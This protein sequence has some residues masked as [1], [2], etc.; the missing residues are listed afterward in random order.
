MMSALTPERQQPLV[1]SRMATTIRAFQRAFG[2]AAEA[3]EVIELAGVTASVCPWLG[4]RSLFNA[5]AYDNAEALAAALPSL[6]DRYRR[7]GVTAWGVWAHESDAAANAIL[8]AAG[9]A[10]DSRPLAMALELAELAP[11]SQPSRIRVERTDDVEAFDAALA[12]A[13]DF[14]PTALTQSLPGLLDHFDGY[15]SRDEDGTPTAALAAVTAD[16]DCGITLVGTAPRARGHGLA[17]AL[18]VEALRSAAEAAC[19]TST[20]QATLMGAPVYSRL[21][22]RG[23]GEMRLWE[24]RTG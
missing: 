10:I 20:L 3:G 16:E 13:Y 5:A 21:G 23:L 12:A 24:V 22:Y 4:F 2:E 7:A 1:L 14:P 15:L 8:G 11:S 17:T 18:T 6:R 9:L 19:T